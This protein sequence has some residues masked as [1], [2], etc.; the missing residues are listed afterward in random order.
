MYVTRR[1]VATYGPMTYAWR[2]VPSFDWNKLYPQKARGEYRESPLKSPDW[3][4]YMTFAVP[5]GPPSRYVHMHWA[6]STFNRLTSF[7]KGEDSFWVSFSVLLV[8][9]H[10][11]LNDHLEILGESVN[12]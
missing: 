8:G 11:L 7:I 5:I 12:R 9:L 2:N 4:K 1:I 6:T 3:F 10:S